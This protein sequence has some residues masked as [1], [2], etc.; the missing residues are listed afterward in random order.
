M[1]LATG[2]PH[3]GWSSIPVSKNICPEFNEQNPFKK[4]EKLDMVVHECKPSPGKV[5]TDRSQVYNS[6][7]V[8]L[9]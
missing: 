5:E 6:Q 1:T 9:P 7:P 4:K 3:G 8:Q 2:M